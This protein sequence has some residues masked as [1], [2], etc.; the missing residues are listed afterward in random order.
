M[1]CKTVLKQVLKLAPSSSDLDGFDTDDYI[2]ARGEEVAQQVAQSDLPQQQS[3]PRALDAVLRQSQGPALSAANEPAAQPQPVADRVAT[4]DQ[5]F[6]AKE[7]GLA[8]NFW[9]KHFSETELLAVIGCESKLDVTIEIL[10]AMRLAARQKDPKA[11]LLE[12]FPKA[13]PPMHLIAKKIES[14]GI[15]AEEL[16][17]IVGRESI[18]EIDGS[19][20]QMVCETLATVGGRATTEELRAAL[21]ERFNPNEKADD[22]I[23]GWPE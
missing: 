6:I 17:V 14:A 12:A 8:G 4:A 9:G 21:I 11:A 20:H 15:T 1:A 2:D 22:S 18:G 13:L 3:R 10:R 7:W 19:E 23:E 5:E 16:L